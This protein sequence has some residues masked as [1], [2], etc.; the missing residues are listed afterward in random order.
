MTVSAGVTVTTVATL[1][2]RE[3]WKSRM[4]KGRNGV[5]YGDVHIRFGL[6]ALS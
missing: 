1:V 6:N 2:V 5:V 3:L 4:Y